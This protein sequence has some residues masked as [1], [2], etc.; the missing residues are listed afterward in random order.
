MA[1]CRKQ[2][3]TVLPSAQCNLACKYCYNP[4]FGPIKPEHQ[5]IDIDFAV[6]GIKDF[7]DTNPSRMIRYYSAGEATVAFDEMKI[8]RDEAF[9]LAGEDLKVELQTNGMFNDTVAD[10]VEEYTDVVWISYDGPKEIQDRNRPTKAGT[11]S[12]KVVTKNVKRFA[13]CKNMQFG[14]R[15]T[16]YPEDFKKMN[17]F[18]DYFKSLGIKYA[19]LAPV[20]SSTALGSDTE[21][22]GLIDFAKEFARSF[23]YAQKIGMFIQTHLIFNFDEKIKIACRACTPCP[24]LTTDGYVSCCDEAMFGPEYLPGILQQLVYGKWDQK[25]KKIIYYPEKINKIQDRNVGN[26]KRE[27]CKTCS[28]AENCAGGCIP[29]SF[30]VTK[31]MYT[32]SEEVCEATKYLAAKIERNKGRFPFLHS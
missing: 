2:L 7:F 29:K 26:L 28:I 25:K 27:E 20:F 23:H 16:V 10:W 17:D 22:L 19:C 6:A 32:P 3:V 14:V 21:K 18:L 5:R 4:N 1:H 24:H 12:H 31:D 8:I 13:K 11:G 15:A 9:K 30:Y